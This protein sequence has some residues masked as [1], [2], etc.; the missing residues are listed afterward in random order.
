MTLRLLRI[1]LMVCR[2]KSV[3]AAAEKLYIAQPTVSVAIRELETQYNVVLFDRIGRRLHLTDAGK[4]MRSYAQHIISLLDEMESR[5]QDWEKCGTLRLGSSITIGT[6]KLPGVVAELQ[7]L[8]PELRIEATIYNSDSVETALLNNEVDLGLIEGKPHSGKLTDIMLGGDELVFLCHPTHPFAGQTVELRRL[9][10]QPFLFREKGSAGRDLVE[11]TLKAHGLE[12]SPLWQ[13][14][15]TQTLISGVIEGL[16]LAI[17]PLPLV[18]MP[19]NAGIIRQFWVKDISFTRR[20]RLLYHENKY[21]TCP[22]R[23]MIRI[24]QETL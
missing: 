4:Q 13:S 2:E 18:Q 21:L 7:K 9:A 8:Y 14:I 15:S 19:L 6:A 20:F 22:M 1:F 5:S 12:I 24:C 23:D 10:D 16:G 3:T 11:S 17:L